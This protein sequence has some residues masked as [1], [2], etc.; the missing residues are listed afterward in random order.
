MTSSNIKMNLYVWGGGGHIKH[1]IN[2]KL[3]DWWQSFR[4]YGFM[5]SRRA[6]EKR[7]TYN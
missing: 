6:N 2:L 3:F 4:L 5:W 7:G 1:T